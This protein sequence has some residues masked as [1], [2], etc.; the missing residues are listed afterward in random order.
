MSANNVRVSP[1]H[2]AQY[3]ELAGNGDSHNLHR[4]V[5]ALQLT[6]QQDPSERSWSCPA[7]EHT[8]SDAD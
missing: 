7:Y 8:P 2:S 4:G 6:P 1:T 5:T 3:V